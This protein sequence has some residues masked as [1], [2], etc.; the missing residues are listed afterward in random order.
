MPL[1]RSCCLSEEDAADV[2]AR[3]AR[4]DDA[5]SYDD[6]P[7]SVRRPGLREQSRVLEAKEEEVDVACRD[8]IVSPRSDRRGQLVA[9]GVLLSRHGRLDNHQHPLDCGVVRGAETPQLG[10]VVTE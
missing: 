2:V 1:V 9:G 3:V 10:G 8:E 6:A 4:G 5:G 7:H